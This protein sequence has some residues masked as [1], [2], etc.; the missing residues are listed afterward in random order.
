MK[1]IRAGIIGCGKIFPMHAVSVAKQEQTELIAVCDV[2]EERAK[3]QAEK[4]GCAYYTD[5]REMIQKENLD[6][7]HICTPHY[8][9]PEMAIYALEHGV[10]V[11]TEKPMAIGL[12]DA[13]RMMQTAKEQ[14]RVLMVSFQNRFNPGSL[15]IK[16][17]LDSGQL[18]KILSARAMIT[19]NRSDEYYSHSDWK[20]TWDKE[21]GG[22]V[23][24]QAIHTLDL[25]NW[26]IGEEIEYVEASM[27]NR[28]HEIIKVEDCA[29]GVIRYR[30]GIN[31]CFFAINYYAYDAP[32]EIE[33]YCEQ[34][35]VKLV[36]EKAQICFQDGR[37]M[38]TDRNPKETFDFGNVKQYWG[39]GHMK[40]I[41]HY[42][43]CL[44]TGETP[45]NTAEEVM[46]T[47]KLVCAIYESGR[48][49][50][51]VWF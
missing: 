21:G 50:K 32:V 51:R 24:D 4:Y 42:Y 3:E 33:L 35:V 9:H 23:I 1:R 29:E 20:G 30:N 25:M 2:K 13:M 48:E 5:Y 39:V 41:N 6:S 7:V 17:V 10:H 11:L 8:L 46:G 28:A 38:I 27:G 49:G 44:E 19:W 40:E 15:L 31:A 36:G 16:N 47:Q 18:G 12:E 37:E 22:V 43:H 34:G 14:N 26:F 45:R